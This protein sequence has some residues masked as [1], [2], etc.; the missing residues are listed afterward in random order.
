MQEIQNEGMSC[1]AGF[2]MIWLLLQQ[3]WLIELFTYL[4]K[5]KQTYAILISTVK[6]RQIVQQKSSKFSHSYGYAE[7]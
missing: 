1:V 2:Y 7:I 6:S 4:Q 3:Q 5:H